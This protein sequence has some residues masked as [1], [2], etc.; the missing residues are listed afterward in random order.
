M[1]ENKENK[2]KIVDGFNYMNDDND[3]ETCDS[4][5]NNENR[6]EMELE[7]ENHLIQTAFTIQ[8][9]LFDYVSSYGLPLCEKLD[10]DKLI[11]FIETVN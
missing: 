5:E 7:Y 10:I 9:N 8:K 3:D 1:E 6:T 2:K 4:E 11:S